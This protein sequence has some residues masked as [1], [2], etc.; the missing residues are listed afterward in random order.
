MNWGSGGHKSIAPVNREIGTRHRP[1]GSR[2]EAGRHPRRDDGAL[3]PSGGSGG[4][5]G[6]CRLR[7]EQAGFARGLNVGKKVYTQGFSLSTR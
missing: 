3:D 4:G 1:T 6:R 5:R 7:V 2:A